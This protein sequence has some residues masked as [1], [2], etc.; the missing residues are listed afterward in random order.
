M[1]TVCAT[2]IKKRRE[3]LHMTQDE[4]AK[5]IGFSTKRNIC[6]YEKGDRSPDLETLC[7]IAD[8]L[9][10][11]TDYLLG[12]E[13]APTHEAASITEQTGLCSATVEKLIENNQLAKRV[14]AMGC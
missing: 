5:K 9:S 2:P 14:L 6:N 12:R 8:Y 1:S 10:C 7:K 11:T 13:E 4:L 3:K